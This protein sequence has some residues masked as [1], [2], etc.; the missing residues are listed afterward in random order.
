M[1]TAV[2]NNF[3]RPEKF[4]R[5]RQTL[6]VYFPHIQVIEVSD[7]NLSRARN[8]GLAKVTTPYVLFGDDDF[9]YTRR[10]NLGALLTLMEIADIAGGKVADLT[11][12]GNFRPVGRMMNYESITHDY[13][14][15]K[16]VYYQRADFIPNFFLA[17]TDVVRKIGW[18]E[19]L[20]IDYEHI[21]FFLMALKAGVEVVFSPDVLVE[22]P[23]NVP[24]S[25]EYIKHRTDAQSSKDAFFDKWGFIKIT[26]MQGGIIQP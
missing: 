12:T 4:T 2:I 8:E 21:D 6:N 7:E 11:Y 5:C 19:Q 16:D 25:A 26:D 15:Y 3:L 23:K 13:S 20:R 14:S 17:K 24:D 22:H 18:D 10:T 9:V 1:I